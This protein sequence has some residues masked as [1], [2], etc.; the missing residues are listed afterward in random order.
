MP[1]AGEV[2]GPGGV[3]D[4]GA[5]RLRDLHG[6]VRRPGVADDDLVDAAAQGGQTGRQRPLLVLH[7]QAG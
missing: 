7:D 1:Q 3:D 4:T 6:A 2:I 5:E